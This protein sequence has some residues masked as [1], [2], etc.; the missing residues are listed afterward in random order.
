MTRRSIIKGMAAAPAVGIAANALAPATAHA[1]TI[2]PGRFRLA[3]RASNGYG[4]FAAL[5]A[6][7]AGKLTKVSASA[8]IADTNRKA[9]R[10][11][12]APSTAKAFQTGFAWD[13]ADQKVKY[14]IPQGVS[15]SADAYSSGYY[16][17]EKVVLVSWYFE[18]NTDDDAA[19]EYPLDKGMRLTFVD[20]NSAAAPTYR[21]VLL[22][23]PSKTG[24]GAYSFKPMR[25]HAGGIMWYGDLLYVT[26]TYKGLRVFDLRTLFKVSATQANVCGLHTDG[27]YQGYGYDYVLPQSYAYDNA[28]TVLRYSAIGLD[29][30]TNPDS[31]VVSEYSKSGTV[32][33]TDGDF[34]G[35]NTG[36]TTT[37]KLVRWPLDQTDRRPSSLTATEAVT[38]KQKKI[39]G[40]VS[41]KNRHYL[42]VSGGPEAKGALRTFTSTGST[43][44]TVTNL[45]VGCEDLSFHSKDA[46]G[47]AYSE[48][49]IW[50]VSEYD[51]TRYVYAVRADGS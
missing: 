9:K 50:N 7:L 36:R 31:L 37:P 24:S 44:T 21:H 15:T 27:T 46:S 13:D 18:G 17:G 49:V 20:Y 6:G 12:S 22:V 16:N 2:T 34:N 39:Q 1:A 4:T 41:R 51:K 48:S 33:Y 30:A 19:L 23:E 29:R 35:T 45:A 32:S 11:T 28:G 10:L 42:S 40:A 25:K 8:V 14:W 5:N 38:V 43:A 47:W 3:G 26:D